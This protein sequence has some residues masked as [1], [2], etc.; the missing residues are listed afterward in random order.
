MQY[1]PEQPFFHLDDETIDHLADE[2][3]RVTTELEE[4][5]SL[6]QKLSRKGERR[7]EQIRQH[8]MTCGLCL[9]KQIGLGILIP[10][11]DYWAS[12]PTSGKGPLPGL[13][14]AKN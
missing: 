8:L 10:I 6:V 11:E 4:L 5:H 14:W 1:D 7:M 12:R 3:P 13:E 9:S 2:M